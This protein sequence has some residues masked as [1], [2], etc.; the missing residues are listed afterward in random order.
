METSVTSGF[1]HASKRNAWVAIGGFEGCDFRDN[2]VGSGS[3][4]DEAD[5][6]MNS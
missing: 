6:N 1:G 3:Y 2:K 4:F 5:M